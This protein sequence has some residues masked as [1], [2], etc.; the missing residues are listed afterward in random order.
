MSLKYRNNLGTETGIAGSTLMK[1]TISLVDTRNYK[2]SAMYC[3]TYSTTNVGC[4]VSFNFA[5]YSSGMY[6][7][8]VHVKVCRNVKDS[9]YYY[10]TF[11]DVPIIY[12]VDEDTGISMKSYS[13]IP[14]WTENGSETLEKGKQYFNGIEVFMEYGDYDSETNIPIV[15]LWYKYGY[16]DGTK[17]ERV[18]FPSAVGF[19]KDEDKVTYIHKIE[20]FRV[21]K[22]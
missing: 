2:K 19:S 7:A 4:M 22:E 3:N 1:P 9:L 18:I 11:C 12:G 15:G 21:Y 14:D 5:D 13:F 8:R 17:D 16:Y 20:V 10:C 6:F